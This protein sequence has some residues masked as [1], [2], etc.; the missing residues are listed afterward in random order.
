M[1]KAPGLSDG[2]FMQHVGAGEMNRTPDLLITN[3]LL[4]RLSYTGLSRVQP[5]IIARLAAAGSAGLVSQPVRRARESP[6]D[7]GNGWGKTI[8]AGEGRGMNEALRPN[9]T[10][11]FGQSEA[12][13]GPQP[14][15]K[16][17]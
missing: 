16:S 17:F 13:P 3:E 8:K 14:S 5:A 12:L 9:Y 11:G 2:G 15:K 4:Y 7:R 10:R 1:K 6:I